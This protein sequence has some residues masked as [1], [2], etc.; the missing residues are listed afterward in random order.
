VASATP[1]ITR[2][3]QRRGRWGWRIIRII[4]CT[5]FRRRQQPVE[6]DLRE[7]KHIEID[8]GII[9]DAAISV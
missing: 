1:Q 7:A 3:G 9:T 5:S 6:I 8:L 4:A 2:P